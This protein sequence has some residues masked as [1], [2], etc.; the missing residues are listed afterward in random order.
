MNSGNPFI[1]YVIVA[2]SLFPIVLL[3]SVLGGFHFHP[4]K[5]IRRSLVYGG[6]HYDELPDL[7]SGLDQM[8]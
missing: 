2:C 6:V 3:L 8:T 1:S 7:V 4:I 5:S